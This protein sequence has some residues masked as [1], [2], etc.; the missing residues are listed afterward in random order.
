LPNPDL[1]AER[2]QKWLAGQGIGSRRV[3]ETWISAGRITVDG[4]TATLGQKVSGNEHIQVDGRT[5]RV[6]RH[7]ILPKTLMYHKPSGEIC[8]RSDPEGRPTIFDSLPHLSQGRWIGVGRLDFLTSGL[9]LLTTDGD[10]ANVLMHPSSEVTREYSVRVLGEVT[11][12][13]LQQ[14]RQG[15]ELDDGPAHFD[16]MQFAGG[17]GSNRWYRV[18]VSEGR[19]R[20][21]RRL[22]EAAGY[23][24]S[25]L[26]RTRYGPVKLPRPLSAGKF[27]YLKVNE[28]EAVY[29]AGGLKLPSTE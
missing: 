16:E 28:L 22:W 25:R 9:L 1:V 20:I 6:S 26:I 11:D 10:L 21:V 3:M 27:R 13:A 18:V 2:L 23:R 15:I 4:D 19:N 5:V 7:P 24:V 12:K 8:T 29:A 14:L 17:E